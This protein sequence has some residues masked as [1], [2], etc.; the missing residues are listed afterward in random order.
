MIMMKMPKVVRIVLIYIIIH[1]VVGMLFVLRFTSGGSVTFG[2]FGQMIL[3]AF[4]WPIN[5]IGLSRLGGNEG[6]TLT[7]A[8]VVLVM[9]LICLG[10]SLFVDLLL[11][12]LFWKPRD[13]RSSG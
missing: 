10:L 3:A 1:F 8:L 12:C 2:K 6:A 7:A 9:V 5:M 11:S 4:L 13:H